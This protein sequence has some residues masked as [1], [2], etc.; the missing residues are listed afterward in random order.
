MK[1]ESDK[2]LSMLEEGT[3]SASEAEEMLAALEDTASSSTPDPLDTA[4]DMARIRAGWR[5]PFNI[6]LLVTAAGGSLL[7][8]KRRASGFGKLFRDLILLPITILGALTAALYYFAK[9]GPW[10][11][12]RLRSAQG[13]RFSFSLPFP[14]NLMRGALEFARTQAD[15]EEVAE[16]LDMAAEF[17]REVE[18]SDFR[19]P[20]TIDLK[21]EGDSVQIYLG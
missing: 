9:D 7:W 19:D 21:D 20:L 15:E 11:H 12:I 1:S 13:E 14:L 3:I 2:I 18:A 8:R 4:P 5:T 16:K 10:F 17:L 6:S